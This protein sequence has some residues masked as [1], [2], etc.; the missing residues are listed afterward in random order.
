MVTQAGL[1]PTRYLFLNILNKLLIF[2]RQ[3]IKV[4]IHFLVEAE[5]G[6]EPA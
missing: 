2:I 4:E 5:A 3:M 1:E 6:I